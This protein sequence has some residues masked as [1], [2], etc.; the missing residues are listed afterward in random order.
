MGLL[1]RVVDEAEDDVEDVLLSRDVDVEREGLKGG[2][3]GRGCWVG[4]NLGCEEGT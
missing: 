1:F 2:I 4:L 3:D